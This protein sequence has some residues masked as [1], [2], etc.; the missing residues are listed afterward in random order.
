MDGSDEL[1]LRNMQHFF[2]SPAPLHLSERFIDIN[3]FC[4][5]RTSRK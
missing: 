2:A 5:A 1:K 3:V 4:K